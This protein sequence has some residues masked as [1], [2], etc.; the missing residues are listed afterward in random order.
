MAGNSWKVIMNEGG[1]TISDDAFQLT[2]S[3][4]EPA[5]LDTVVNALRGAT[6]ETYGQYCGLAKAAEMIGERWGMLILRDLLVS[7]KTATELRSGLPRVTADVLGQRLREM[8]SSGVIRRQDDT[9]DI[10]RA[11]YELTDYG[12]SVEDALLLLSRWGAQS[13]A[14]P[15]PEDIVTADSLVIALRSTFRPE[16][17]YDLTATFELHIDEVVLN[18][19]VDRG[20]LRV[21][22]GPLPGA[23]VTIKVGMVLKNLLS[24]AQ[25]VADALAGGQVSVAAGDP[26]LVET[27]VGLFRF[28]SAPEPAQH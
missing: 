4:T 13:L 18:A 9:V 15:R 1:V 19:I 22:P 14:T 12:R 8:E 5:K 7:A 3:A 11:V 6:Y 21:T 2:T 10:D 25:T 27:F 28:A 16:Q 20:D 17:S 24:G 23:D 26:A